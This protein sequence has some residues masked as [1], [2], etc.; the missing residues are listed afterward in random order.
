MDLSPSPTDAPIPEPAGA[1]APPSTPISPGL[2]WTFAVASALIAGAVAAGLYEA[3]PT[4]F[5]PPPHMVRVMGQMVNQPL[6]PD[7]IVADRKNA[8]ITLSVAGGLLAMLL[9]LAGGLARCS[10]RGRCWAA[11]RG[12]SSARG[13]GLGRRPSP[14]RSTPTS[15]RRTRTRSPRT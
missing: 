7:V 10:M 13:R 5:I 12:S 2:L 11:W 4:I 3:T 9:G 15:I 6:L 1:V 8:M 14:C